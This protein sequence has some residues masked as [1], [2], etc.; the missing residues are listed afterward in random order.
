MFFKLLH[1]PNPLHHVRKTLPS[2]SLALCLALCL[3]LPCLLGGCQAL[4]SLEEG[5]TDYLDPAHPVTITL[6]HYY[7]SQNQLTFNEIVDEFNRSTGMEQGV[8]VQTVAKGSTRDLEAAITDSASGVAG[9]DAPPQ[10]FATY[11]DK[12]MELDQLGFIAD[13]KTYFSPE[14]LSF[15][16]PEFLDNGLTRDG[17]LLVLPTVK[18][19][20]ILYLNNEAWSE[21]SSAYGRNSQHLARWESVFDVAWEYYTWTDGMTPDVLW[22][23]KALLG[24]DSLGNYV[25]SGCKQQGV[26]LVDGGTDSS[27]LLD[28][29][30][31]RHVFDF[32]CAGTAL[33]FIKGSGKYRSDN[34]KTGEI[35]GY[36]SSSSGSAH[37]PNWTLVGDNDKKKISL[38]ALPFP[39]FSHG[40][41]IAIQ[42]GAGLAM[43]KGTP[44]QEK[45]AALFLKWFTAASQNNRFA[46]N[47][48]YL[49]VQKSAYSGDAYHNL[50][51]SLKQNSSQESNQESVYHVALN[52]IT[53]L[54]TYAPP[55]SAN[56][57]QLRR[58]LETTLEL[59]AQDAFVDAGSLREDYSNMSALFYA[60]GMNGRF[61]QWLADLCARLDK[62]EI[63]YTLR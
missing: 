33:G 32:Y 52:Q 22:D 56:S 49:P 31:L 45:G 29:V 12:A 30:A 9:A 60:L 39:Y 42:Q 38:L 6:W 34:V 35:A 26:D 2:R 43:T 28:K 27:A 1:I 23:G 5:G 36:I 17:R 63:P 7:V 20:D 55:P 21:F 51:L 19:T 44:A 8:I 53:Q 11:G 40:E 54:G 14:D 58:A 61:D 62:L 10:L 37:F 25:I 50:L 13:L 47:T 41:P 46:A 16:M 24:F 59:A 4:E 15:F 3:A 57:Y 48:G 18:S